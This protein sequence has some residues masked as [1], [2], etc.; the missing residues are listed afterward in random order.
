M[1]EMGFADHDEPRLS[2]GWQNVVLPDACNPASTAT[3]GTFAP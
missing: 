1:A 3:T 2:S